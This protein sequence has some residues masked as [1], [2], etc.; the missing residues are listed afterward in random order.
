MSYTYE[1]SQAREETQII[2]NKETW[3][4]YYKHSRKICVT[5]KKLFTSLSEHKVNSHLE[6][7]FMFEIIGEAEVGEVIT[8]SITKGTVNQ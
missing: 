1:V 5:C 2:L 3:M 8:A 4:K 7:N 6:N